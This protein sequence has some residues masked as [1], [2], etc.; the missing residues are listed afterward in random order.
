M[1][2]PEFILLGD[3]VWIDFINT[4]HGRQPDSPDGLA[5]P[6]AYHRWSKAEKLTSDAT[7]LPWSE[8]LRLPGPAPEHR[9]RARRRTP[10]PLVRHP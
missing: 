1:S 8:V 7:Q 10:T 9:H 5:D 3:A 2:D 4:A 6:A